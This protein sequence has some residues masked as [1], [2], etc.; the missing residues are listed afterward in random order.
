MKKLLFTLFG[1][2]VF[3]AAVVT[4][5]SAHDDSKVTLCHQNNGNGYVTITADESGNVDG[6]D[7]HNDDIIP[8]FD[9]SCG[10]GRQ[11]NTCHY[12]GKNW[13]ISHRAI[14]QNGCQ[15]VVVTPTSLPTPSCT[16]TPPIA[17]PTP[18]STPA[19]SCTPTPSVAMTDT[20]TPSCTPTPTIADPTP[21]PDSGSNN[22]NASSN[23]SSNSSNN[24]SGS[25]S[26]NNPAPQQA[27]LGTMAD[28]GSFQTNAMNLTLIGGMLSVGLGFL[29]YGKEKKA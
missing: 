9:Y 20:P 15:E 14:W 24:N 8:P 19:L 13:D 26:N 4:V 25:S 3:L 21:T 28:T 22:N 12:N 18:T 6:H 17:D 2:V 16:P 5:V 11:S 1:V 7:N 23:N 29:S 10:N 27:V